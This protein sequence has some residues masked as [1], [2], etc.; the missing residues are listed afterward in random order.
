MEKEKFLECRDGVTDVLKKFRA[1][2][3][4]DAP[5]ILAS[6]LNDVTCKDGF[7]ATIIYRDLPDYREADCK[8]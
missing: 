5:R 3:L 6:A 8:N 7:Q 1:D 4:V 2:N